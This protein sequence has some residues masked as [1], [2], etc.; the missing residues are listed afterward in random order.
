MYSVMSALASARVV[1][2]RWWTHSLFSVPQTLSRGRCRSRY[3]GGSWTVASET[4]SATPDRR[5]R[6][7]DFLGRRGESIVFG[8]FFAQD[9]VPGMGSQKIGK[10]VGQLRL[11]ERIDLPVEVLAT[12]AD[13]AGIGADGFR[14]QALELEMLEVGWVKAAEVRCGWRAYVSY[15]GIFCLTPPPIGDMRLHSIHGV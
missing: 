11:G 15:L 8:S 12:P 4:V 2:R 10:G 1:S 9:G 14:L 6:N 7:P 13:G 5:W 3:P